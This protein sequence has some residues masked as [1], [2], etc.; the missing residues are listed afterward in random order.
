MLIH[1]HTAAGRTELSRRQI[2]DQL[3]G[4]QV[5]STDLF[6]FSGMDSWQPIGDH[7]ALTDF[8]EAPAE[9]VES[10]PV[11]SPASAAPLGR[12]GT[13]MWMGVP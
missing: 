8:P 9:R 12:A 6:W 3:V 5:A 2:H 13:G 11:A 7:P 4:G 10:A 1:V